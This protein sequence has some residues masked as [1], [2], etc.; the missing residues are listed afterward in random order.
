MKGEA[1]AGTNR[2]KKNNNKTGLVSVFWYI[3]YS[4]FVCNYTMVKSSF[5]FFSKKIKNS[6]SPMKANISVSP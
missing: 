4:V 3:L 6:S 5:S 1:K 2:M